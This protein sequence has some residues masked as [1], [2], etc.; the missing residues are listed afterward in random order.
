MIA[1]LVSVF[2][3]WV[4]TAFLVHEAIERLKRPQEINARLVRIALNTKLEK[5][6]MRTRLI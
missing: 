3:I 5:T 2:T 6:T 4:L 1:A